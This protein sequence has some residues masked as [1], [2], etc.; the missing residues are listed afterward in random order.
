MR[1]L[2]I[3][4]A[5]AAA[6]AVGAATSSEI[7]LT[8]KAEADPATTAKP[9]HVHT[10]PAKLTQPRLTPLWSVQLAT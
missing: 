3:T 10:P 9:T 6:V 4:M 1:R 2:T 8:S 5:L 7:H